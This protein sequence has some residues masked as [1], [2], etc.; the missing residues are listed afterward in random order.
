M[1]KKKNLAKLLRSTGHTSSNQAWS[2]YSEISR[3]PKIYSSTPRELITVSQYILFI[4]TKVGIR[5][6]T[7]TLLSVQRNW[8]GRNLFEGFQF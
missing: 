5:H 8:L 3:K 1:R 2:V 4:W 6:N 7:V